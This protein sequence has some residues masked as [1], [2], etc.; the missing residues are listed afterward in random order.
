MPH[1]YPRNAFLTVGTGHGNHV[2]V[3]LYSVLVAMELAFKD[4][5]HADTGS[6]TSGHN[7]PSM[8]SAVD[9][10]LGTRL[11]NALGQLRCTALDGNAASVSASVYPHIRYL[12]HET[13]FPPPHISSSD[14]D[15]EETLAI[16]IQCL[17]VIKV[18]GLLI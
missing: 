17:G 8:M 11:G 10:A 3:R 1:K 14:G 4:N 18:A 5:S 6:W 12:R 16:A 15:I 7:V 2:L 9:A 13:D